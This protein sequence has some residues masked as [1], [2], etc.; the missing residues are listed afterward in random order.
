MKNVNH[1]KYI[2]NHIF[3]NWSCLI[4]IIINQFQYIPLMPVRSQDHL[5]LIHTCFLSSPQ[6]VFDSKLY[7][8]FKNLFLLKEFYLT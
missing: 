7:M 8:L 1:F 6:E 3:S 2:V 5:L 4:T